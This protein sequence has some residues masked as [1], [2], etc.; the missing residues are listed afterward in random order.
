MF[1]TDIR[2]KFFRTLALLCEDESLSDAQLKA[3]QTRLQ[4]YQTF[5]EAVSRLANCGNVCITEEAVMIGENGLLTGES[6]N[7]LQ[8]AG[9]ISVYNT[10]QQNNWEFPVPEE[11]EAVVIKTHTTMPDEFLDQEKPIRSDWPSIHISECFVE[12]EKAK[13]HGSVRP[14]RT[15]LPP[16]IVFRNAADIDDDMPEPELPVSNSTG[17]EAGLE[18]VSTPEGLAVRKPTEKDTEPELVPIDEYYYGRQEGAADY[19]EEK[20]EYRFKC[21]V[22]QRIFFSNVKLMH[23]IMGHV[24]ESIQP[25]LNF[26]ALNQCRVCS[27]VFANAF[28]LR[29]HTEKEH[30]GVNHADPL[31]AAK[32][33][34]D[35][36]QTASQI[37][38]QQ[39]QQQRLGLLDPNAQTSE[40][41]T[42]LQGVFNAFSC[43][44]CGKEAASDLA[45]AH[46]LQST[47][48]QRE[49]PYVCRLCLFRSSLFEDLLDH[50]KKAHN[51][52]NHLLCTYCL[53]I[54]T[55]SDARVPGL[56]LLSAASIS[57]GAVSTA[58]LGAGVGQTQVYLQHLRMHQV[59]HQLRRCL[60]C[61]LNFTN[62]SDYQV[63][64]RLDHKACVGS[65][66][67][68]QERRVDEYMA[69]NLESTPQPCGQL[70][71][72]SKPAPK[73]ASMSCL[74]CGD[75]LASDDH[76]RYLPCSA[77][78]FATCCAAGFARHVHRTHLYSAEVLAD[79]HVGGPM[80]RPVAFDWMLQCL[81]VVEE[82]AKPHT[83]E[84]FAVIKP[85]PSPDLPVGRAEVATSSGESTDQAVA[86]GAEPMD[87]SEPA[88]AGAKVSAISSLNQ[89]EDMTE[90]TGQSSAPEA[91][92]SAEV[93][94]QVTEPG[95]AVPD[96]L[97]RIDVGAENAPTV[98]D[99]AHVQSDDSSAVRDA[100]VAKP[101]EPGAISTTEEPAVGPVHEGY[102]AC[103]RCA[104]SGVD[105][106][107]LARHL[108]EDC[109]AEGATLQPDPEIVT[110]RRQ[111][112]EQLLLQQ[113]Q[114]QATAMLYTTGGGLSLMDE[115]AQM[116][117]TQLYL[118]EPLPEGASNEGL[119]AQYAGANGIPMRLVL[120]EDLHLEAGQTLVLIQGEDGQP[121]FAIVNQAD[122]MVGLG[123]GAATEM[124]K[125]T[126]GFPEQNPDHSSGKPSNPF[127]TDANIERIVNT[128]C[129]MRGA[130]LKL[131]QMLSLQD[132]SLVSP[133]VQKMFER[134]RQSADFMPTRQMYSVINEE[135]GPD[136]KTKVAS[137][138]EK[139][140]AAASIGQVHRAVM[141]DGSTVAMKI[142]YPGI[143]KSI[144]TDVANIML[145][146]KRFDV[147]PRGMFAEEAIKVAKRE[148][149]WE[150]D[151]IREA[152]Y[153]VQFKK[154]LADEEAFVVPRVIPEL[155][156]RRVY[157]TEYFDGLVLDD[158]VSLPQEVRNWLG[159]QIL[160]LC[161][162][163]VFV[164][165]TM[166]TDPNWSNFIY[167]PDASKIV[168]LDFGASRTYPRKFVDEYLRL[169][170]AAADGN[171]EG[172]LEHSRNLGFLTGYETK[173]FVDAHTEA[174]SVL[175]EAFASKEPFDFGR[176]ST[177]RHI[178][179]LIPVMLEH[180]LTPPPSESYSLHRKMS[181]C[182]LLCSKLKA[183]VD[184][185][186]L[187]L[188]IAND[189]KYGQPDPPPIDGALP[190]VSLAS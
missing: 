110:A 87:S 138:E 80:V 142:Q 180:R 20:A 145:V 77:C 162:K 182:F 171:K 179:Q 151:Y 8:H 186:S 79:S 131:G 91:A 82:D 84:P 143:S 16:S 103:P 2:P 45:L 112:E 1:R 178:N 12:G 168:L 34:S 119:V 135:L 63:H 137:F 48:R 148:L 19:I 4:E 25:L 132:N 111:A 21:A 155:S 156:S 157:T 118:S 158:C 89:D 39:Q 120:P 115:N 93:R 150:C 15:F 152:A 181:G 107:T 160:N 64:R 163:E 113:Q 123:I 59:R 24:D 32:S 108:V 187:F 90:A 153:A 7:A 136:W 67:E 26:A 190:T 174:V 176:Q 65:T 125:R 76:K 166:Q 33:D 126:L 99:T 85:A 104:L 188:Q 44:I 62:K 50:F 66:A 10:L 172:I 69:E 57:G 43:R 159:Q 54:F 164:F 68:T 73:V 140:F 70:M 95:E 173:T 154:L 116:A 30:P 13:L 117:N 75:S 105:G 102:F 98:A 189:Y 100:D 133:K 41:D 71:T 167:T 83:E 161:L 134:V 106:N 29:A 170:K 61:K 51:G 86:T 74:E 31:N 184:C 165:H 92:A 101:V 129:R 55:P 72:S 56:P 97:S 78:V 6:L 46:H 122:L 175:G 147:L 42:S 124:A 47:H 114:Q 18:I 141:H 17:I 58:G 9:A 37:M 146:L 14:L 38:Q 27:L 35:S 53:R 169:I 5:L 144:E 128:L 88:L 3:Y 11:G 121:Q 94:P 139:P 149:H 109:G 130:A 81:P 28:E 183:V 185:R 127:L 177:T 36:Q 52:S 49:M 60:S 22:C 96:G 40:A 23:H